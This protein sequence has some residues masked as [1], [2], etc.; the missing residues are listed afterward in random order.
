MDKNIDRISLVKPQKYKR[1][2]FIMHI[3]K[4]NQKFINLTDVNLRKNKFKQPFFY[5]RHQLFTNQLSIY[6]FL[7]L[8]N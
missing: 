2:S 4:I 7:K 6:L 5:F 1:D 8:E 3:K